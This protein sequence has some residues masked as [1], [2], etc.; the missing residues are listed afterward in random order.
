MGKL[1]VKKKF[2]HKVMFM[3]GGAPLRP[4]EQLHM[5]GGVLGKWT[6]RYYFFEMTK[7]KKKFQ[8]F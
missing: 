6:I 4:P 8:I 7:F 3:F 5:E 1:Q 2:H